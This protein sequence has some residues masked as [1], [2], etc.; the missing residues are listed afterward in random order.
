MKVVVVKLHCP[1]EMTEVGV[2][3]FLTQYEEM[4]VTE[5]LVDQKEWQVHVSQVTTSVFVLTIYAVS[6]AI[7][8][9]LRKFHADSTK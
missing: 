8:T 7:S 9:H 5:L 4:A 3:E 6:V 1:L 2:A